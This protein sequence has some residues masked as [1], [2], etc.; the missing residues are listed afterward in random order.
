M[1]S[2][3][4]IADVLDRSRRRHI[5][6]ARD[7][8]HTPMSVARGETRVHGYTDRRTRPPLLD[9]GKRPWPAIRRH[10][11]RVR[12]GIVAKVLAAIAPYELRLCTQGN[13]SHVGIYCRESSH[14]DR[15]VRV[16]S[17]LHTLEPVL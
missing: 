4:F 17:G 7:R 2:D 16:L 8:P 14:L 15:T 5:P 10:K 12:S 11:Q 9:F 3:Y 6:Y 13:V 1:S